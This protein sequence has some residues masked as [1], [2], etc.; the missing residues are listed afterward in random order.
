MPGKGGDNGNEPI[1]LGE[2]SMSSFTSRT[3]VEFNVF[4]GTGLA[5]SE[6]ISVKSQE[7]VVRYNTFVDQQ[8]AMLS[9]R[10]VNYN[11]AYGNFFIRAGGV[12]IREASHIAV[13][14]NYFYRAGMAFGGG[15]GCEGD[16]QR[17]MVFRNSDS[18]LK[19]QAE[20]CRQ[21]EG[22]ARKYGEQTIK[23]GAYPRALRLMTRDKII[24][25]EGPK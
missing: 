6:T 5:D 20:N 15:G 8:N 24:L 9:F 3:I 4:N 12:R 2:G 19:L 17:G 11:V 25:G 14:N 22:R 23:R 1:R 21:R 7:N 10:N 16:G 13:Y 18:P